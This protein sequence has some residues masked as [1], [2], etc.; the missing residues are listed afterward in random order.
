MIS[1]N[2]L[3][4]CWGR[5]KLN[6][7][8]VLDVKPATKPAEE[9]SQIEIELQNIS[10][11]NSNQN[12]TINRRVRNDFIISV[13]PDSDSII[14]SPYTIQD[15]K[16]LQ[17]HFNFMNNVGLSPNK[18]DGKQISQTRNICQQV[19]FWILCSLSIIDA[20]IGT[21]Q[22]SVGYVKRGDLYTYTFMSY[23]IL[24]TCIRVFFVYILVCNQEKI[25]K[26]QKT[27]AS[28]T[29][30]MSTITPGKMQDSWTLISIWAFNFVG[31]F[32]VSIFGF[33][34]LKIGWS[35]QTF[36][37]LNSYTFAQTL[38]VWTSNSTEMDRITDYL[39]EEYS[40]VTTLSAFF[41]VFNVGLEFYGR[42]YDS[43]AT[44]IL[45]LA[46]FIMFRLLN[47]FKFEQVLPTEPK[48]HFDVVWMHF[49]QLQ[50]ISGS[51]D[52]AFGNL[53]KLIHLNNLITCG[54]YL[55]MIT[56]DVSMTV[57]TLLLSFH[58]FK[59]GLIYFLAT[60][61]SGKVRKV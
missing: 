38:F 42:I 61:A 22:L 32:V 1:S 5:H 49:R 21:K 9:N 15:S 60:K 24:R 30:F 25:V 58:V 44:D 14:L 56:A 16:I 12:G 46:V 47:D 23:M 52:T 3:Q 59:V 50:I 51:I 40:E 54:Y 29:R 8:A 48:E 28:L 11:E 4:R 33:A 39:W 41:A 19:I 53:F 20:I 34:S 45:L 36:L 17:K 37:Q 27:I 10:D 43:T 6:P 35:L 13:S 55:Q 2:R 7:T 26:V 31:S 57:H 18:Y